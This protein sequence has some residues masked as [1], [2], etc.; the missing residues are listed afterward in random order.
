[1]QSERCRSEGWT[2]IYGLVIC[3]GRYGT[4]TRYDTLRWRSDSCHTELPFSPAAFA[5]Q[6]RLVHDMV[7]IARYFQTESAQLISASKCSISRCR[8]PISVWCSQNVFP[9]VGRDTHLP[10]YQFTFFNIFC[11]PD[12][13]RDRRCLHQSAESRRQATAN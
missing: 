5:R 2:W 7:H 8:L 4:F 3:M 9:V 12:V 6:T 1:M 10:T 13:L 11:S